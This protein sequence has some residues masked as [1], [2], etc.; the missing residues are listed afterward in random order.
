MQV[1]GQEDRSVDS[2]FPPPTLPLALIAAWLIVRSRWLNEAQPSIM[3][4]RTDRP[5]VTASNDANDASATTHLSSCGWQYASCDIAY[6][7]VANL[8]LVPRASLDQNCNWDRKPQPRKAGARRGGYWCA[9]VVQARTSPKHCSGPSR[10]AAPRRVSAARSYPRRKYSWSTARREI[11][12][13][14]PNWIVRCRTTINPSSRAG[15]NRT[16]A[17]PSPGPG[18]AQTSVGT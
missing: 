8:I 17:T 11:A 4:R 7:L 15:V 5:E 1:L 16:T 12:V 14:S 10:F 18:R 3:R 9:L 13:L 6:S 2:R